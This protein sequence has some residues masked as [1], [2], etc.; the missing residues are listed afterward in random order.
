MARM[1]E[2]VANA[3]FRRQFLKPATISQTSDA[4]ET[5][6]VHRACSGELWKAAPTAREFFLTVEEPKNADAA[7]PWPPRTV[8]TSRA[9]QCPPPNRDTRLTL[10]ARASSDRS[11]L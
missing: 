4:D 10:M 9:D 3:F 7:P 6:M 11:G 8:Q 2:L 1:P 5:S